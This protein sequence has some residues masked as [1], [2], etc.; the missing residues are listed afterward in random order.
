VQPYL[1]LSR[2]SYAR[3]KRLRANGGW[4]CLVPATLG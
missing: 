2:N 1:T 4:A 3:A